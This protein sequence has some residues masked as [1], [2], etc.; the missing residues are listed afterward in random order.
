V[1]LGCST[2]RTSGGRASPVV[3]V[4]PGAGPRAPGGCVG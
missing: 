3:G 4:W 1:R 2:R